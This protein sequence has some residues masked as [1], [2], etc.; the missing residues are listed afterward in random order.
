MNK[1]QVKGAT[2]QVT[3]KVK[4]EVGKMT[5][6]RSTQARGVAREVKGKVQ[7]KVGNAKESL[8]EDQADREIARENRKLDR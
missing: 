4:E 3:G 1:H 7:E 2:N 5:G 6:D 8:R